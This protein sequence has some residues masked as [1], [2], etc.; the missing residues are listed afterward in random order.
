[1]ITDVID[2]EEDLRESEDFLRFR[3]ITEKKLTLLSEEAVRELKFNINTAFNSSSNSTTH[4][5]QEES[6]HLASFMTVIQKLFSNIE[7]DLKLTCSKVSLG[8]QLVN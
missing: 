2:Q 6:G 3:D 7:D 1:M 4:T 5:S 8:E